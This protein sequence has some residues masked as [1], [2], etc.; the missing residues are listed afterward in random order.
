MAYT[1][2][3]S[4]GTVLTTI[5]DGTINTTST[6]L[7]LPGKNFAGYGQTVDTNFVHQLEN[8]AAPNPPSNPLRGQ[9]WYNTN[10]STMYVC[11]T[12]GETDTNNWVALSQSSETGTG[13][14]GDL[15]VI[16]NIDG[17]NLNIAGDA[18]IGG[19]ILALNADIT[20][21]LFA[22]TAN[23]TTA[24]I[25]NLITNVITTGSSIN[26]GT[27]TGTWTLIGN[28]VANATSGISL[29]VNSGNIRISGTPGTG[30]LTDNYYYSNGSPITFGYDNSNV[31]SFLPTYLPTYSG[32][33]GAANS[34]L[35]GNVLTT[36]STSN[37]GNIT[38]NWILTAGSR[39]QSTY[40]DIAE[41]FESD[42]VYEP[43][44]VVEMG[45]EKEITAVKDELSE[46]V[47]G[48][49]SNTAAYIMNAGS[50][51]DQTHPPIAIS[52]RVNVKVVGKISKGD[53]LVSAG[54]GIA[55]AGSKHEISS[56]NVIGRAL[57]DK[58][59]LDCGF[60]EAVVRINC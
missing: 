26:A 60:V 44:T 27:M 19:N 5:P 50:G 47:F 49:I 38:G 55:R 25:G 31:A 1:I 58:L 53:R 41:R 10:N 28:G 59:T 14:F 15:T 56:L 17:G 3:K 29:W 2:V 52:G 57:T 33:L 20:S 34:T 32:T 39:L 12:D 43:G 7:G 8:F 30:I 46:N 45:G 4:D 9:L 24:N 54:N 37:V 23:L 35:R 21:N 40:A 22:E 13:T 51:N 18:N 6:T 36:G 42:L 16:G 11:P 48:V